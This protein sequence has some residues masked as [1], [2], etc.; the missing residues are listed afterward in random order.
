MEPDFWLQK[1][2]LKDIAFHQKAANPLLVSCFG[3]LELA[4]DSRV[5]LPL[6]GKTPDIGWLLANGYRV[7]GAELSDIAVSELF[8]E[9]GLTPKISN[10]GKLKRYTAANIDIFVGD[11]FDLTKATLGTIDAVYD[12]AA[13]VALPEPMR[14]AYAMH[15][16]ELTERAPQLVICFEYEQALVAGPPFSVDEEIL[17]TLYAEDYQL[18]CIAS[19]E[20]VGGLKRKYP[21]TE[22]AWLLLPH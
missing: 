7:A 13:L 22:H 11:I 14:S 8:V 4:A 20:V 9:L 2:Q 12:R 3:Q 18:R 10:N 1:W 16:I 6:C 5:F 21:A 15:L 17:K 19:I